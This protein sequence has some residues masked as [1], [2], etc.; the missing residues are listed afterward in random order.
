[1]R[2]LALWPLGGIPAAPKKPEFPIL[3]GKRKSYPGQIFSAKK[4]P[5]TWISNPT[6][7]RTFR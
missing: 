7:D 6:D 2:A 4:E 1:L 5:V 3:A